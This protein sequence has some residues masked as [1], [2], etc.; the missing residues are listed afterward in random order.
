M[1]DFDRTFSAKFCEYQGALNETVISFDNHLSEYKK[2]EFYYYWKEPNFY[3]I[4]LDI[5]FKKIFVPMKKEAGTM[6]STQIPASVHLNESLIPTQ[7]ELWQRILSSPNS[8]VILTQT[9]SKVNNYL[10]IYIIDP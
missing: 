10:V 7:D 1:C 6:C 8:T 9:I 2:K 5:L 4:F 3:K